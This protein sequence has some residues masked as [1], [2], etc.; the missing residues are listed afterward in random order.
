MTLT[1]SGAQP[2]VLGGHHPSLSIN[3]HVSRTTILFATLRD[4]NG[5]KVATWHKRLFRGTQ[6]VSLVLPPKALH[7]GKRRLQ[8]TWP[9]GHSKTFAITVSESRLRHVT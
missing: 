1:F 4:A 3:V 5:H 6:R 9:G 2:V 8:L 7:A